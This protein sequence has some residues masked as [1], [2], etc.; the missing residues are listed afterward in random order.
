MPLFPVSTFGYGY[1]TKGQDSIPNIPLTFYSFH[2]SE[3]I[4]KRTD[5]EGDVL[6]IAAGADCNRL[7]CLRLAITG[8]ETIE[9]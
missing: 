8:K 4:V 1:L 6:R 3:F 9:Y 7:Y 5:P 2:L